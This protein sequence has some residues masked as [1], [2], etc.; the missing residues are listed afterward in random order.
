[1][2]SAIMV[3]MPLPRRSLISGV[4]VVLLTLFLAACESG[5]P[6]DDPSPSERSVALSVETV[7]GGAGIED[8]ERTDM[9]TAIGDVLSSYVVSAFL[10]D[11]PRRE[12]VPAFES[13]TS[14]AAQQAALDIDQL[15][16]SP[17]QDAT[18]MRATQLD[19][20]LSFLTQG[21]TPYGATAAVRFAFEATMADGRTRDVSLR[22]R[23]L[24]ERDQDT[25]SVF[26]YDVALDDGDTLEESP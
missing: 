2:P 16:A 13:F 18:A 4:V 25:W 19:A 21:D 24:L 22:G 23:F 11:F 3:H 1:M 8:S 14:G 26:G 12:F 7:A 6:T 20:R 10:G 5:A 17:V 9:E 15:T